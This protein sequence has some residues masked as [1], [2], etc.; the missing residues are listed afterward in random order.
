MIDFIY[1]PKFEKEVAA[2]ERRFKNIRDG[3]KSFQMLCEVQFHPINPRVVITPAKLHRIKQSNIQSL[4]KIE[5]VISKSNLQPNQFPRMWFCAQ[6]T[7][8]GFL[9]IATHIDNYRD[10]NINEIALKRLSDIF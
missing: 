1:H 2:L 10:N 3:L 7:K 4:W 9:C 6:G 5:L 8:I